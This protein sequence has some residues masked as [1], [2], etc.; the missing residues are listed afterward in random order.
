M[1]NKFK[2]LLDNEYSWPDYYLFKFITPIDG[3]EPLL[4]KLEITDYQET[5]SK[6]GNYISITYR[7]LVKSSD[8][9]MEIYKLAKTIPGVMTL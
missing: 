8:E 1:D 3:K 5:L 7:K 6:K 9:V 2:E 4:K